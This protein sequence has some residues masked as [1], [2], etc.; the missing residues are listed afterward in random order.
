MLYPFRHFMVVFLFCAA[1]LL[2]ICIPGFSFPKLH[3]LPDH[4]PV[5]GSVVDEDLRTGRVDTIGDIAKRDRQPVA[6]VSR[7]LPLAFL[8]P[9][10]VEMIL[11]GQQPAALTPDRLK[12]RQSLP[13][14][15]SEQRIKLL[16]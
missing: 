15:W 16:S 14:A 9:D 8:S 4:F 6:H 13:I 10:I 12:R 7:T 11:A 2:L 3:V 1:G 5:T